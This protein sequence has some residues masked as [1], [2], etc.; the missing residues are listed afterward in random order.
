MPR[1]KKIEPKKA[2]KKKVVKELSKM[3]KLAQDGKVIT[4]L[5][6]TGLDGKV[7]QAVK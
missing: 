7:K 2:E 1:F 5:K 6:N 3:E 4:T